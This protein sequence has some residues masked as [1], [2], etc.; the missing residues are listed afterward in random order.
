MKFPLFNTKKLS[1]GKTYNLNDPLQRKEYFAA[2]IGREVEEIKTYLDKN[3]FIGFMLAKKMAGKGVYSK[4]F[5]EVVGGDRLAVVSVGD[6]IRN[7]HAKLETPNGYAEVKKSVSKYYRGLM[8]FD[9]AARALLERSSARISVPTE[10]LLAL[11]KWEISKMGN[12]AL[13]VD[14]LPRS[15]DQISVSL[16]FR[17]LINY[18]DV[19]DFFVLI[20]IP[21]AVIDGR[22]RYRRV[23]PI[24]KTSRQLKLLPTKFIKYDQ[25]T[26][27]FY[28]LCDNAACSGY[29]KEVLVEKE[30]DSAG[31][32]LIKD[33][34][35]SD[36]KLMEMALKLEGIPRVLL[37]NS[38]P[39][40]EAPKYCE[41]YELTHS[42][43]YKY[44]K[45]TGK[46]TSKSEKWIIKDDEG[47]DSY[48]IL[49]APVVVSM[50]K[51]IHKILVG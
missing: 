32:V 27:Q 1:D 18:R 2:R 40:K 26:K 25:K 51:Q 43:S 37:R 34:L 45:S 31:I 49:S 21:E 48:S 5:E 23:C 4:M 22:I 38:V 16:Y 24:C 44:D 6:V 3:T 9:E 7:V 36:A 29:N 42:Y 14:G 46:L 13:F 41:E 10:F 28:M 11:L 30:G 50:I 19:P 39:V 20:D 47:V 17:D 12:K 15:L 35:D 33:R 8:S